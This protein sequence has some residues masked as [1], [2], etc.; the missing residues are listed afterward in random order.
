MTRN[1]RI[2]SLCLAL[3]GSLTVACEPVVP[4]IDT[5]AVNNGS[6]ALYVA[7]VST[8]DCPGA[9]LDDGIYQRTFMAHLEVFGERAVL[10]LDGVTLTGSRLGSVISL[11]WDSDQDISEGVGEE[12]EEEVAFEGE[13]GPLMYTT[14]PEPPDV[15]ESRPF[16]PD[17][18]A[19]LDIQ[20]SELLTGSLFVE[21]AS[22]VGF[23]T[24]QLDVE[25]SYADRSHS[26]PSTAP[27]PE[28]VDEAQRD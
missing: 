22:N 15:D 5:I 25:L 20:H 1:F 9:M 21:Q 12:A 19:K 24:V 17:I 23:C 7:D 16:R 27:D 26:H 11:A 18:G 14:I 3:A 13:G 2:S 6:Y 28:K 8:Y 10:D 4:P